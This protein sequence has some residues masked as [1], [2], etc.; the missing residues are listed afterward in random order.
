MIL[1]LKKPLAQNDRK[2]RRPVWDRNSWFSRASSGSRNAQQQLT[3]TQ[4]AAVVP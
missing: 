1:P 4:V 3:V 2:T